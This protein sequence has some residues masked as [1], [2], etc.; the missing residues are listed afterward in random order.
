V[1]LFGYPRASVV[2]ALVAGIII[3][4]RHR[5]NLSRLASGQEPRLGERAS[6]A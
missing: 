6:G 1:A 4:V 3:I 2:A 5:A